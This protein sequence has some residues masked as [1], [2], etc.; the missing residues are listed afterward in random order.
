[1]T[2]RYCKLVGTVNVDLVKIVGGMKTYVTR[3]E[4]IEKS[5]HQISERY[6]GHIDKS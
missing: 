6:V 4:K 2:K 1:M 5:E 3:N